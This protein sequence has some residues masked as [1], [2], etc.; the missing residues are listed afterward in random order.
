MKAMQVQRRSEQVT[1]MS[2][3]PMIGR[4]VILT[5]REYADGGLLPKI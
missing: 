3:L 2:R 5:I 4:V 1:T